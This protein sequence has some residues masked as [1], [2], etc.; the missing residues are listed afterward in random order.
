MEK[1]RLEKLLWTY[2]PTLR[3]REFRLYGHR[4]N[5]KWIPFKLTQIVGGKNWS[6]SLCR[7]GPV[8]ETTPGRVPGVEFFCTVCSVPEGQHHKNW[9]HRRGVMVAPEWA[10]KR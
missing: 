2:G 10:L 1:T 3:W 7:T 9:C 8:R 6:L 4:P 5:G